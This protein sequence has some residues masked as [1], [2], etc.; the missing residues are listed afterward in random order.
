VPSGAYASA[1]TRRDGDA[2]NIDREAM[3]VIS[4]MPVTAIIDALTDNRSR[5]APVL[6]AIASVSALTAALVGEYVFDIVGCTLCLYQRVPYAATTV[7]AIVAFW[8]SPSP[9][10]RRLVLAACALLFA[11]GSAIAVYQVG[12]QQGWWAEP[13][14]CAAPLPSAGS[15]ADLRTARLTRPACSEIDWSFLGLSLAALNALY[16]GAL[17][18]GCL[19]LMRCGP[20]PTS[21]L[22][23]SK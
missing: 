9:D 18:L 8:A 2:G 11:V 5:L 23:P 22:I 3:P 14:V 15:L 12:T 20:A 7:V 17:A 21:P 10:R 1:R 16:S 19:V 4:I 6:I 13:S